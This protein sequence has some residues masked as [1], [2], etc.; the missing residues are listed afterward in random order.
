MV[1]RSPSRQLTRLLKE[2]P[3]THP[4]ASEIKELLTAV[5]KGKLEFK[6]FF[7]ILTEPLQAVFNIME[8]QGI[9]ICIF[10]N[11]KK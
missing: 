8:A 11:R 1:K 6:F 7:K 2:K 3:T 5:S 10:D 4:R 9:I